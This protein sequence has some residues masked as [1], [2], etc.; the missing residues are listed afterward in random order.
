MNI[1]AAQISCSLGDLKANLLKIRDFSAQA[2]EAS[3]DLIVFPEMVDTG[4]SMPVI[5]THA[6]PWING[7]VPE[8]QRIAKTLSIAIV[9]GVAERDGT[10]I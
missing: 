2:K 9:S 1:A 3:A 7:A 6:T 5:Q 4:Y 10:S 8:L